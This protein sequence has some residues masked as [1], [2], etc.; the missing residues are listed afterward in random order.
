MPVLINSLPRSS[1]FLRIRISSGIRLT[2]GGGTA[3]VEAMAFKKDKCL[4]E[5]IFWAISSE[6]MAARKYGT[7][8][9]GTRAV[10]ASMVSRPSV[11]STAPV[12]TSMWGAFPM[13]S[14]S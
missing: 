5:A 3:V 14:L 11:A 8:R 4:T 2:F 10:S 7:A 13:D 12:K 6:K 1:M 9:T